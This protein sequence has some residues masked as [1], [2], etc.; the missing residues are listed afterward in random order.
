MMLSNDPGLESKHTAHRNYA[1][2]WKV[3]DISYPINSGK[4]TK[5]MYNIILTRKAAIAA[6]L[7]L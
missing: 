6:L 1:W 5:Y 4:L 2:Q 3:A 7:T